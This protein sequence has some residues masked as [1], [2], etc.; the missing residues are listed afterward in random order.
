MGDVELRQ[1]ALQGAWQRDHPGGEIREIIVSDCKG[2]MNTLHNL[3]FR[4]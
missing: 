2:H 4:A 3:F 1:S